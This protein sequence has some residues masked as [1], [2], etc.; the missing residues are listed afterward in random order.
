MSQI[1]ALVIDDN[2][3]NLKVLVQLLQRHGIV[4]T[5]VL[6]PNLLPDLLP[7]LAAVDLVFLD[8]EMPGMNGYAA[9]DLLR[10]HLGDTPIIAC[11]VHVSEMNAVLDMGFDGFIGKPLERERFADQIARILA[12]EQ[13]W[14]RM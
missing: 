4:C 8:L 6:N 7:E 1:H 9:K 2:A 12:G 14:E 11:T 13:V 10:E 3:Q 5:D